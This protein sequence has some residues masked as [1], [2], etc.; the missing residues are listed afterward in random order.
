[1]FLL[2]ILNSIAKHMHAAYMVIFLISIS[3]SLTFV[4]LL[5]TGTVLMFGVWA[6]I[7][8]GSLSL[9]PTLVVAMAGAALRR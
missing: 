7:A 2:N 4:E 5:V 1:M 6:V 9:K 3:E 8:T